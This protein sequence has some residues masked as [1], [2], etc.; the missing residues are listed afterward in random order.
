MGPLTVGRIMHV[1]PPQGAATMMTDR[2]S[3][4]AAT[5]LPGRASGGQAVA[6][7]GEGPADLARFA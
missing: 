3:R 2:P 6:T 4:G 1:G 5:R 7:G